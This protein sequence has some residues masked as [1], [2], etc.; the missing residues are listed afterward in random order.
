M[1]TGRR[2]SISVRYLLT[3]HASSGQDIE[4]SVRAFAPRTFVPFRIT[5][6]DIAEL[7]FTVTVGVITKGRSHVEARG[8]NCLVLI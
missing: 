2:R 7:R 3:Y 5:I 1:F 4:T 8:G 6:A